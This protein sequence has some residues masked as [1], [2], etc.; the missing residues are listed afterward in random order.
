MTNLK[1]SIITATYNSERHIENAL[2]SVDAQTYPH[3]EYIIVDGASTDR[4]LEIVGK[5]GRCV[6]RV[7]SE[8]DSGI[9]DAFNK[10]LRAATGDVIYFLNSDD[11]LCEPDTVANMMR[12]FDEP[13]QWL[14]VYGNIIRVDP[15][16]RTETMYGREIGVPEMIQGYMTPHPALFAKRE[17]YERFQGFDLRFR[18]AADFDFVAK[19]IAD[20]RIR[21]KFK[22]VNRP[23]ARFTVGGFS[24]GYLTRLT[25]LRETEQIIFERFGQTVDLAGTEIE[26]NALFRQWLESLI[27]HKRGITRTLIEKGIRKAAIFGT[28]AT[29]LYLLE[30]AAA[31][32]L[33]IAAFIDNSPHMRGK[34]VGGRDV[35]PSSWLQ[36]SDVECVV[37]S[38]EN[39]R[40]REIM[41]ELKSGLARDVLICS[42]KDLAKGRV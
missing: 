36:E 2:R 28:M 8:P 3:I 4:T 12:H 22:Y 1:V 25:G 42:W 37:F 39:A 18:S 35:H 11:E 17:L 38:I 27:I 40:D 13:E 29:A 34:K 20:E 5:Y 6:S 21:R 16:L 26:N 33:E 14:A 19:C 7:I 10:G 31:E 9:Y 30:D 24:T 32:G 23:V 15:V 41:R